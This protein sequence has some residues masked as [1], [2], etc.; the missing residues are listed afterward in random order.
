MSTGISPQMKPVSA[1]HTPSPQWLH[2]IQYSTRTRDKLNPVASRYPI[3]RGGYRK[4]EA[5]LPLAWLHPHR[6]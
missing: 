2:N 3:Y 4:L 5:I 1:A 6:S